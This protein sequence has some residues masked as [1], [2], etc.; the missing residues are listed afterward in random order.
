MLLAVASAP[1]GLAAA[2]GPDV[3]PGLL[4]PVAVLLWL[5]LVLL[6]DGVSVVTD[7]FENPFDDG[8][9]AATGGG[10]L[11]GFE[12]VVLGGAIALG[13]GELGFENEED[14]GGADG[15]LGLEN[16]ELEL[17]LLVVFAASTVPNEA[18]VIAVAASNP[19][20]YLFLNILKTLIVNQSIITNLD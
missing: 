9:V 7:G 1:V 19:I 3:P 12:N 20:I 16:P 18:N 6:L 2:V 17:E 4:N 10:E 11:G 8:G 5:T 13:G 15:I 14:G